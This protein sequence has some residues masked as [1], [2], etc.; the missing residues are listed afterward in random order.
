MNVV[1]YISKNTSLCH[2]LCRRIPQVKR[3]F[4]IYPIHTRINLT[5][6]HLKSSSFKIPFRKRTDKFIPSAV[7]PC[8]KPKTIIPCTFLPWGILILMSEQFNK[9]YTSQIYVY[10][11]PAHPLSF[12]SKRSATNC[13]TALAKRLSF[14]RHCCCICAAVKLR[15]G[16]RR[17]ETRIFGSGWEAEDG[18]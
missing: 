9:V 13:T 14:A 6:S 7:S 12:P 10:L 5:L 4:Y 17:P 11:Y 18:E 15:F 8:V 1:V 2:V 16:S 3:P